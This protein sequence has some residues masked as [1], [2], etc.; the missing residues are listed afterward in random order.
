MLNQIIHA[1]AGVGVVSA[2]I[3]KS[4]F[5]PAGPVTTTSP[6]FRGYRDDGWPNFDTQGWHIS[7]ILVPSV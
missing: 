7:R 4:S 1:D 6:P 3:K 2:T 5:Q